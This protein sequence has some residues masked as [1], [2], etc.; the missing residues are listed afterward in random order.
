VFS[1]N[2]TFRNMTMYNAGAAT[3]KFSGGSSVT[4]TGDTFVSGTDGARVVLTSTN[5]T[6][7]TLNKSSDGYVS[8]DYL[9]IDYCTVDAANKWYAGANS[10]DGGHNGSPTWTFGAPP[11]AGNPWYYYAMMR[12]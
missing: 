6:P 7:F 11:V 8:S 10:L 5:T 1:G 3:V 4:M 2:F 9:N 12:G